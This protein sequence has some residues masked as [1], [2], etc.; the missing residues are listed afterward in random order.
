MLNP[1]LKK[2][3]RNVNDKYV[4]PF[5]VIQQLLDIKTDKFFCMDGFLGIC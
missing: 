3:L 2:E 4:T 5:S 1:S